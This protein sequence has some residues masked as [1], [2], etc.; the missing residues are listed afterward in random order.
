M[1]QAKGLLMILSLRGSSCRLLGKVHTNRETRS[2][3]HSHSQGLEMPCPP[4][5]IYPCRFPAICV[6]RFPKP[7]IEI[8]SC[9]LITF[10]GGI[11]INLSNHICNLFMLSAFVTS[12]SNDFHNL[13][14][15]RWRNTSFYL[16]WTCLVISRCAPELVQQE[17]VAIVPCLHLHAACDFI[18]PCDLVICFPRWALHTSSHKEIMPYCWLR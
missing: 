1:C 3:N 13:I 2:D 15:G 12:C 5:S 11:S 4:S 18:Y 9:C 10:D 17:M 7:A 6:E 8:A 14:I 16:F